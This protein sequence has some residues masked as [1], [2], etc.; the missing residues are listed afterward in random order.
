MV[1][2]MRDD[3]MLSQ[4]KVWLRLG[5]RIIFAA[6]MRGIYIWV[7]RRTTITSTHHHQHTWLGCVMFVWRVKHYITRQIS[8][9]HSFEAH[10]HT[11]FHISIADIN[12]QC[13]VIYSMS[14]SVD[15]LEPREP[16]KMH[17]KPRTSRR[18]SSQLRFYILQK[19]ALLFNQTWQL[20][21]DR[22]S[23]GRRER[24]PRG[25]ANIVHKSHWN[26]VH[27]RRWTCIREIVCESMKLRRGKKQQSTC[28]L[29]KSP[30]FM[31]SDTI[32]ALRWINWS[33]RVYRWVP[34]RNSVTQKYGFLSTFLLLNNIM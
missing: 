31:L 15:N 22:H 32:D 9:T 2:R 4:W 27:W 13:C 33:L 6:M 16:N 11:Y 24:C 1:R 30:Q 8:S 14:R 5:A 10:N 28:E 3:D 21:S 34:S 25:R 12:M 7:R 26:P 19:F 18:W 20:I 17:R 23:F 29:L